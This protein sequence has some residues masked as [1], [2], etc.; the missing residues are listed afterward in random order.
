MKSF[1][2]YLFHYVTDTTL[3]KA[4]T[5]RT[6]W[7]IENWRRKTKLKI[8]F[9]FLLYFVTKLN[10]KNA[11]RKGSEQKENTHTVANNR[12]K[13][14]K[15]K[16]RW[17][18][19]FYN[20]KFLFFSSFFAFRTTKVILYFA[21]NYIFNVLASYYAIQCLKLKHLQKWIWLTLFLPFFSCNCIC[22]YFSC[23]KKPF[24]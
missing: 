22:I 12:N 3:K 9:F 11:Q 14:W 17:M 21:Q 24:E 8:C 18:K 16:R 5:N 7:F 4:S 23:H 19:Y 10:V 20:E 1:F 13:T 2:S 6:N 15:C